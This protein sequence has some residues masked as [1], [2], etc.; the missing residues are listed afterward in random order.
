LYT[1]LPIL[2]EPWIDIFMNFVLD[3]PR[4]KNG[5]DSIFVVV[6]KILKMI[7]FITCHKTDDTTNI[8]DLLFREIIQLH[9]VPRSIL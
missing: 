5:T 7:Y 1:P 6:D 4:S 9:W 2:N 3:L 8:P